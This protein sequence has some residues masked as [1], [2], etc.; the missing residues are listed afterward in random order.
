[1]AVRCIV[2]KSQPSLN[3]GVKGQGHQG[4]KNELWAA[5]TPGAYEWYALASNSVQQQQQQRTGP[6]CG[7]QGVFLGVVHQFYAGGK[8]SIQGSTEGY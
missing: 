3:L 2:Q 5:D 4:Q 7:C 6:F 1:M 8:I